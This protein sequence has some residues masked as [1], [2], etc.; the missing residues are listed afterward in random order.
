MDVKPVINV[1]GIQCQPKVDEK[2]NI[3]YDQTHI[4]MLL[5]FG[6]LRGATRYKILKPSEEYPQY[7]AIYEFNSKQ[8]FEEYRASPELT[9]ALDK[10]LEIGLEG[11]SADDL[12]PLVVAYEPVWAIGT[13]K[14]ATS[15]Q[16]QEVHRFLREKIEK[17]F[18]NI[19][20]KSIRILYGGSVKPDN[21]N[22]LMHMSDVDGAL[23][24]GASLDAETFS[25]IVHFKN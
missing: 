6:G 10:Q 24:G 12:K 20:A 23:V 25:K 11:F 13:G 5:K 4:P 17:N 19:L 9:A 8:A 3:W 7:L 22:E 1:V 15:V 14:T 18:G 21:I 16:A 2:F